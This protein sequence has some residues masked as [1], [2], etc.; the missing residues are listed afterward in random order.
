MLRRRSLPGGKQGRLAAGPVIYTTHMGHDEPPYDAN[1]PIFRAGQP[2][3]E[4]SYLTDAI[5][6]EAVEFIGLNAGRPFFLFAAYNAVHSPLQGADAYMKRFASI[7]DVHRRIFAAMLA[8]LDDGVG[9]ILEELRVRGLE[10]DTLVVFLSDNGGPTRE[11]TSSNNPLRGEKSD[12]YEGG[13]RV[14]FMARWPGRIA[15]GG[16]EARPVISLDL[17][18]TAL[19]AG[20]A[21]IPENF[22]G[23]DLMP[24][25]A[26]G[27][28]GRPHETLYWR[29]GERTALRYGDWK[30][31]RNPRRG[32]G[33]DWEL[34]NL[35]A[36]VSESKNLAG[37]EPG[38]VEELKKIWM[39]LDGEMVE[40]AF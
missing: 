3:T 34:Y 16:V 1:N 28:E 31:L 22:D 11:L 19:A 38:R 17:A 13:I 27:R 35:E 12:V 25:L 33:G 18:A 24:Y 23:V 29:Q 5:T 15:A 39:R 10:R 26:G 36:D 30:L 14:P 8:N 7:E 6:R 20:D 9:R 2:V 40:R 21:E 4:E 37:D 32:Q